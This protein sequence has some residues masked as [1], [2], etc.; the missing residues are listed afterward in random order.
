MGETASKW[1]ESRKLFDF[2]FLER[3]VLADN[4]VVFVE[5]QFARLGT[6]VLF[7]DVKEPGI[8]CGYEL[9]LDG[10]RLSHQRNPLMGCKFATDEIPENAQQ[11]AQGQA[12]VQIF[13]P[14]VC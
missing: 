13:N 6:C 8:R 7:G 5:L 4:R 3:N 1:P 12:L 14:T 2:G 9:D 11:A 10:I